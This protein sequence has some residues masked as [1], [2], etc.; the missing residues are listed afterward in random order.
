MQ[1]I[2]DEHPV[3][4]GMAVEITGDDKWTCP[5]ITHASVIAWGYF[6]DNTLSVMVLLYEPFRDPNARNYVT[7]HVDHCD[8]QGNRFAQQDIYDVRW[9]ANIGPASE[10]WRDTRGM[11]W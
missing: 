7:F 2:M 3:E 6:T 10:D 9:F 4:L 5:W 8:L 1:L 11:D